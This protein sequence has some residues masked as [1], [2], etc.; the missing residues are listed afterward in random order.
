MMGDVIGMEVM[1]G[2][3]Q[4]FIRFMLTKLEE[5]N[6]RPLGSLVLISVS[7]SMLKIFIISWLM[8]ATTWLLPMASLLLKLVGLLEVLLMISLRAPIIK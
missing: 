7:P 5:V 4:P 2:H 3:V 8:T 1:V 6:L